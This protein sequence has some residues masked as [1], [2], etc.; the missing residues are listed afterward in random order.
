MN[1]CDAVEKGKP[2][3]VAAAWFP[4]D[5]FAQQ[6]SD[7]NRVIAAMKQLEFIVVSDYSLSATADLADVVLPACTYLE[8][9]DLLSSN[10]FYLQ[11]MPKIIDPLFESKSDLDAIRMVA[12]K[13]GVGEYFDQTPE[14]YLKQMMKH[15]PGRRRPDGA[16]A[17]LGAAH[18]RGGAPEH[19]PDAVRAVLQPAVP[20]QEREDRVLR[21]DARPLRPGALRPQ[22]AHRGVADEPALQEVPP[23]L[24]L[25]P[26]QVPHALAV[27]EPAVAEGDQQRR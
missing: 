25:D 8:K 26:H 5:N 12:E 15:R 21:R 27:R 19:R 1:F 3:P 22:R 11:Y 2:F 17:H 7:R 23:R 10:N 4:I 20:D 14:E 16:R 9:T 18:D 24:P 13:M 6:M